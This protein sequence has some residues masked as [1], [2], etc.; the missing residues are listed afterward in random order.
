MKCL[1]PIFLCQKNNCIIVTH[2]QLLS[3]VSQGKMELTAHNKVCAD[4]NIIII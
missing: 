3:K 1:K 4:F 2:D